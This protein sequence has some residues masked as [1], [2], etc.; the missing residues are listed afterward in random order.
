MKKLFQAARQSNFVRKK[1]KFLRFQLAAVL[2]T[3]VDFLMTIFFKE[4]IHL[5]YTEAVALGATCGA[6][7]A[8]TFNR[9]WVFK[10]LEKHP[11]E[12]AMRYLL[13][14]SGGI[15]LNTTGTY[16]FTSGLELPY[17]VSKA[18]TALIIGFTYSYQ[19]SKRFVFYA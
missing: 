11:A 15:I 19:F 10:S 18:I 6:V 2:A 16:L 1:N 8:F 4:Y 13:V 9:Y 5:Y 14:V 3:G 17:L 7:A 12:Q